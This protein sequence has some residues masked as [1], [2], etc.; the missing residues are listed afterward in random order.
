MSDSFIL[1]ISLLLY[2]LSLFALIAY[3][4][5]KGSLYCKIALILSGCAVIANLAAIIT[6]GV[7]ADRLP[8]SN[9]YET[10]ILFAFLIAVIYI[11]VLFKTDNNKLILTGSII[12][13]IL[14]IALSS[15]FCSDPEPLIPALRSNWLAI[16]VLFC[17]ISY[18][19]FAIGFVRAIIFIILKEYNNEKNNFNI[20]NNI[21]VIGYTFLALGITTGSVWGE[22][23]WGSYWNW[24]PKEIWSL[25]TFI[26]YT[27]YLHLKIS[28]KLSTRFL[29]I[30]VISG[31]GLI[32]F[33]YFGVNYLLMGLH[34]Y[35]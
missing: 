27:I 14:L 11:L 20:I 35:A 28:D 22:A 7:I 19:S 9:T 32:L 31:F 34:S 1:N 15:F 12:L 21:I 4:M 2:V 29:S 26:I 6:R 16:H 23:A 24:D 18:A 33:T 25:I 17:I 3:H 10:L 13:I 30:L 5:I 8:F